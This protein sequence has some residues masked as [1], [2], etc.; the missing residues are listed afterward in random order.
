MLAFELNRADLR[1]T[2]FAEPE[3]PEPGEGEAVLEVD[4]FGMTANNVTYAVFGDA[5]NYWNFFPSGVEG[6]G[7]LPVWG[8]ATVAASKHPGVKEGTRV[9]GYLPCASHLRVVPDRANER[10]FIDASEHRKPLPSA[11]QRYR[12]VEGDPAYKAERENEQIIFWPLFYTSFLVDD[13]IAADSF[14]GASAIAISSAS[15]K[16]ALIAAFLLA[17]REDAKLIGLTSPRNSEWVKG[18]GIYDEV[19][20]YGEVGDLPGEDLIYT[21]F[22]GDADV[23]SAV[24]TH[25]G[26]GLRHSMMIGMTH[27]ED[28]TPSGEGPLPGPKPKFFFAPDRIKVRGGDWGPAELEQRVEEAWHPF[29][30]WASGW[31]EAQPG[32]GKET[33][34]RVYRE[35]LEGEI[36]PEAGPVLTLN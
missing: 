6:W 12:A 11:Y 27:H 25:A 16:T 26:D 1:E 31:L 14:F 17:Q 15:S 30:D 13:L 36:G 9:Y 8:F 5:M 32:E 2:R 7:R 28:M 22:A 24:H 4:R 20:T 3:T 35:V 10:G 23:R 33:L 29:A 19:L 21:D 34:E 18:L